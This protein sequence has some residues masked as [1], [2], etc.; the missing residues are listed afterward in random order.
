MD[1]KI[2]KKN[3]KDRNCSNTV[4]TK[5]LVLEEIESGKEVTGVTKMKYVLFDTENNTRK[6]I[7]P[8]I[9]K[10]RLGIIK[11]L[12]MQSE[13]LYFFTYAL[14]DGGRY[15]I[16]MMRY[17][18]LTGESESI[19]VFEDDITLYAG[20]KRLKIFVLNEF[21][22][23]VQ[24]EYKK[25]NKIGTYS[26]FFDFKSFLYNNNNQQFYS[27][28]DENLS[29]NG[30]ADMV[31]ISETQCAIKTGFSLLEDN[32]AGILSEDEA[33]VECIC[34]ANISQMIADMLIMQTNIAMDVIEQVY[35]TST[36]PYIDVMGKYFVYSKVNNLTNEEEANFYDLK[37]KQITNC[38]NKNVEKPEDLVKKYV[39]GD[40]PYIAVKKENGTEFVNLKKAK[41]AFKF[42]KD[43]QLVNVISDL[44]IFTGISEKG[45][46]RKEHK[47]IEIFGYPQQNTILREKGELIEVK[48]YKDSLYIFTKV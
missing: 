44:F 16:R 12:S 11:N 23:I 45:L 4:I 2:L 27:I 42:E 34:F 43:L 33:K 47:F 18:Y 38:I 6:E 15:Q 32:R 48:N 17:R 5:K 8:E 10:Y 29:N 19:F 40:E 31:L 13:Y 24:H 26:G 22:M 36:L 9:N 1:I 25:S 28:V 35:Y 7:L 14:D 39:I 3:E 20:A 21:Y 30:I 37:T 46:L 41:L